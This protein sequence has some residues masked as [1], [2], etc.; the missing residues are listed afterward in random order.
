MGGGGNVDATCGRVWIFII[1]TTITTTTKL[2]T[3]AKK[4]VHVHDCY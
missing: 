1:L 3:L 4:K 2:F